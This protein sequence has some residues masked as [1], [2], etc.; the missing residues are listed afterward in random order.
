[1]DESVFTE[2]LKGLT[3]PHIDRITV[4][5][6]PAYHS[7][8]DIFYDRKTGKS[9]KVEKIRFA[10]PNDWLNTAKVADCVAPWREGLPAIS[11]LED[12]MFPR[13]R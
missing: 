10:N 8:G 2:M 5:Y 12:E 13:L 6:D 3:R 4:S 11:W 9:Y 7:V 1:M